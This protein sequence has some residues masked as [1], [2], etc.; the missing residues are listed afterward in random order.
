MRFCSTWE[1]RWCVPRSGHCSHW[2][3]S[4]ANVGG[5]LCTFLGCAP[6]GLLLK[7]NMDQKLWSLGG[8]FFWAN[9]KSFSNRMLLPSARLGSIIRM[10][11]SCSPKNCRRLR[12]TQGVC[13]KKRPPSFPLMGL[14]NQYGFLC[15]QV[16]DMVFEVSCHSKTYPKALAVHRSSS[17]LL[18][19]LMRRSTF[20]SGRFGFNCQC[21][22]CQEL[23]SQARIEEAKASCG[24]RV[25]LLIHLL[26]WFVKSR[27]KALK[28]PTNAN[29][30]NSKSAP[31]AKRQQPTN[32]PTK[33]PS[34][35]HNFETST[36]KRP[37]Q[38]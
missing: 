24:L 23:H 16:L 26:K 7:G 22:R 37:L 1:V 10:S 17:R 20:I 32:P 36:D 38:K 18:A 8:P 9:A 11:S 5:L 35:P 13:L 30:N 28:K 6:K 25:Y 27:Q 14:F 34:G 31:K 3:G 19:S 21:D 12:Q 29:K 2:G 33:S 15:S 4:W